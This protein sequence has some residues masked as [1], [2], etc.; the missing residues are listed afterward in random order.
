MVRL[1]GK[2][3]PNVAM[4]Q[5]RQLVDTHVTFVLLNVRCLLSKFDDLKRDVNFQSADVMCLCETWLSPSQ[6]SPPLRENFVSIR[7]DSQA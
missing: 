7:S 4:L 1:S 5:C 2:V 3:S 6:Q